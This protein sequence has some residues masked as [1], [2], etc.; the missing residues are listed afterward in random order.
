MTIGGN[1][2]W[3]LKLVAIQT[4]QDVSASFPIK[5]RQT[6]PGD[7]GLFF[8]LQYII[9]YEAILGPQDLYESPTSV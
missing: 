1:N 4:A 9:E 2:K 3:K 5:T 8:F 6:C 7:S